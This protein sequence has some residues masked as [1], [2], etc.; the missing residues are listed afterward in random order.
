[1]YINI[2]VGQ[3]WRAQANV[4]YV[5]VSFSAWILVRKDPLL[6]DI[7][8]WQD[9]RRDVTEKNVEDG[10]KKWMSH[11]YLDVDLLLFEHVLV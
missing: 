6:T 1:M 8:F 5:F 2:K 9:S 10:S 11:Y 4:T 7:Q 3:F